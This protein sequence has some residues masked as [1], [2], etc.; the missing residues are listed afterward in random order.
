MISAVKMDTSNQEIKNHVNINKEIAIRSSMNVVPMASFMQNFSFPLPR[1][2]E[3]ALE[4]EKEDSKLTETAKEYATIL[5]FLKNFKDM[6]PHQYWFLMKLLLYLDYHQNELDMAQYTLYK[7]TIVPSSYISDNFVIHVPGLSEDRPSVR[8]RDVVKISQTDGQNCTVSLVTS[9]GANYITA[10]VDP[11]FKEA[12]QPY[13]RYDISFEY[14]DYCFQCCHHAV[15][16]AIKYNL[17]PI[18][19]PLEEPINK[20]Q[21]QQE[22]VWINESMKSNPEQQ[23]AVINI[24]ARTAFPAPYILF[25]P[26]GT[27]KTSTLVEAISQILKKN[28]S[29]RILVCTPSNAAA[30]EVALRLLK[31]TIDA[32]DIYRMYSMSRDSKDIGETLKE[33]SNFAGDSALFVS[34]DILIT[35]KIV[36]TTL[37]TCHRLVSYNLRENHFSYVFVDEAGQA[38]EPETL[39]PMTL[40]SS[41][42]ES[43]RGRLHGQIVIAGDPQQLG[44]SVLSKIAEPL[45]GCSMLERLMN[46]KLYR[47]D[48]NDKFNP[49]YVTKLVLNYRCHPA[50]LHIPNVLFYEGELKAIG[51]S[52][53]MRAVDWPTLPKKKFPVIFHAVDGKEARDPRSPSVYNIEE[54]KVAM[55]YVKD[56]LRSKIGGRSVRQ[57]EIG[58]VTPYR[59]QRQKL[60]D[61]LE[62]RN[63]KDVAVGT[64]ETFQGQEKDIII[65]STV[66]SVLYA[67]NGRLHIGFL[68]NPKRFNVAV[69]RAKALLIVIGNPTVLQVDA[70]WREFIS[71]CVDNGALMGSKFLLDRYINWS[72]ARKLLGK[73]HVP[74]SSCNPDQP[75]QVVEEAPVEKKSFALPEHNAERRRRFPRYESPYDEFLVKNIASE[76]NS[77][78]FRLHTYL[79]NGNSTNKNGANVNG[80]EVEDEE[81][82]ARGIFSDED[83]WDTSN[84]P[85]YTNAVTSGSAVSEIS[86]RLSNL[87]MNTKNTKS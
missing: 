70:N 20:I 64:V 45:L 52:H 25:G 4:H 83:E 17:L 10:F 41:K 85:L 54:V 27:G 42:D 81:D 84:S 51:G 26:P 71:Y 79:F 80:D 46:W 18:L 61:E 73:K 49:S 5:G 9:V 69:T 68:S 28:P 29:N 65:I 44:P 48:G 50:I 55:N 56:L 32:H 6:K 72:K 67:H 14:S 87:G 63:W 38:T 78:V 34:K 57:D 77:D 47:K 82:L 8:A 21:N 24:M 2:L 13:H 40:M 30:D 31:S 66:R 35:K 43:H 1:D 19:F 86:S 37:I 3:M 22:L 39:I 23:Q 59:L 7:Q 33:C 15:D 76:D 12:F 62:N 11:R 75:F 16:R 58:I 36:I 74:T 60:H 53:T